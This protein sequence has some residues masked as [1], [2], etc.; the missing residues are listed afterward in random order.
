MFDPDQVPL[1]TSEGRRPSSTAGDRMMVALAALALLGGVL[2]AVSRL[3]PEQSEQISQATATPVQSV[4][5]PASPSP[6]PTPKP[7]PARTVTVDP[8]PIPSIAEPS[9]YISEWVRLRTGVTL[10][11][12]P[13][14]ARTSGRLHRGEAAY[15]SDAPPGQGGFEGWLSVEGPVNGWILGDLDNEAMFDRFPSHWQSSSYV[16][17]LA[18]DA[19][20]FTAFGWSANGSEELML[21]SSDGTHW[22]TAVAPSVAWGRTVADGPAGWLMA[23]NVEGPSATGAMVWQSA[24]RESWERLG[25]LP[26]AMT[27]G[28]MS[29]V[30]SEAGYVMLSNSGTG[31]T[32][33]WFSADGLLWT[34]RPI[35]EMRAYMEGRLVAT[36]LGFFIWNLN[37]PTSEGYGAFSADGW[38]WSDANPIGP[39]Q[40]VDVVADGDH[41]LALG[42]G[43]GGTRMW[44]GTVDGQQLTWSHDNTAPFRGAALG[45]MVSDGERVIVLGWDRATEAPL[46]WQR[47][48]LSWQRHTMPAAFRGLPMEAVGGPQGVVAVGQLAP[49]G[50]RAP[51]FWHLGDGAVWE[52][53]PSPVMPAPTPPNPQTCGPKPD[54]VLGLLNADALWNA[55]CFGDA[56][57]TVRAYSVPCLGC[58]GQGEGKWKVKW[59]AQPADERVIHLAPVESSDWGS[60]DAILHPSVRRQPPASRWLEVTGHYDDPQAASCRWTPSLADESWYSGTDDVIAGCRAWFVVTSVRPV[61]GP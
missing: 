56:P 24:D 11:E 28:S 1:S 16:Y 32:A 43:P 4:E 41:L 20:G 14:S 42:R 38:T 6:R 23:G 47:D 49:E 2:I 53:E 13:S 18:S 17:G 30:G 59:L 51:V 36:P 12:S 61:N 39:G 34:E 3:L 54:D 60:T 26:Q 9:P 48:G 46:W 27:N 15:V 10:L 5:Q 37:E 33:V 21:G 7:R 58:Y 8:A 40:I 55:I 45:S 50:G 22:H 44:R 52:R 35:A 29:L 57:I 25:A 19:S 31:A